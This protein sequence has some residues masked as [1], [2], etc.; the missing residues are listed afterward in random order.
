M[1]L[2]ADQER[3]LAT[4][5]RSA[6]RATRAALAPV[7]EA[8][9]ILRSRPAR[10]ERTR[11]GSIDRLEEALSTALR[12][13]EQDEEIMQAAREAEQHWQQAE[14]YR[15]ELAMSAKHIARAEGRKLAC[16][17]L[18]HEDLTQEGI[19]GLLRAAK[20]FD[21]DRGIRFSTYARWWV[22]AQM[23]RALETSG[24]T[25]RLPG[26]AV[27]QIRNLRRAAERFEAAGVEYDVSDLAAEVGLETRRAKFLLKQGGVV[28]LDQQDDDGL[29]VMDRMAA[30]HHNADPS[31]AA[32]RMQILRRMRGEMERLLDEREHYILVHHFGL[33]TGTPR[34]MADIGKDIGLSRERVRQIEVMALERLRASL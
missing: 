10:R 28:S 6:E 20:R 19:I 26:G 12:L 7:D 29:A 15:W 4:A 33:D 25:V 34:T 23:T 18:G 9:A 27:E 11:A 5:I 21:P 22:R 24:R 17:L 1:T 8:E 3:S 13:G 2:S 32:M 31:D 14:R 30:E 16:S